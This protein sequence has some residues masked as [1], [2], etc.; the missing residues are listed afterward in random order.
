MDEEEAEV[1]NWAKISFTPNNL[2]EN[3]RTEDPKGDPEPVPPAP[4]PCGWRRH[5]QSITR[6]GQTARDSTFTTHPAGPALQWESCFLDTELATLTWVFLGRRGPP[7]F[8]MATCRN[9]LCV[10]IRAYF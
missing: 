4:S 7:C 2:P 1:L 6:A 10:P 3:H 5:P 8:I 9:T